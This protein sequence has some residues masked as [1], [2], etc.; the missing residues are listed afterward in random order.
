MEKG[1]EDA[2]R[3]TT[4]RSPIVQTEK[5]ASGEVNS[6]GNCADSGE[7]HADSDCSDNS[8]SSSKIT[9]VNSI[10]QEA[11]QSLSMMNANGNRRTSK[12]PSR[13]PDFNASDSPTSSQKI[14]GGKNE[15]G[16]I[17]L[18]SAPSHTKGWTFDIQKT[19][20]S[21]LWCRKR[22]VYIYI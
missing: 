12:E 16:K 13:D 14:V 3:R 2:I 10:E 15:A 11:A 22:V 21:I 8:S 19:L 9:R 5:I 18:Y 7:A 17:F 20:F 6:K 1:L 4:A